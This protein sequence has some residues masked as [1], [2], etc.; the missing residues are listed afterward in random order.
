MTR[1]SFRCFVPAILATLFFVVGTVNPMSAQRRS[2]LGGQQSAPAAPAAIPTAQPPKPTAEPARPAEPPQTPQ[3]PS[4]DIEELKSNLEAANTA[5]AEAVAE[6]EQADQ[7]LA[8]VNTARNEAIG[9]LNELAKQK[10]ADDAQYNRVFSSRRL[11]FRLFLFA[12]LAAIGL[13]LH[14]AGRIPRKWRNLVAT[15]VA[16]AVLWLL[17]APQHAGAATIP[18]VT[19]CSTP[20]P[21]PSTAMLPAFFVNDGSTSKVAC[22]VSGLT[23]AT[24]VT[25]SDANLTTTNVSLTGNK[26]LFDLTVA[27]GATVPSEPD[28]LVDGKVV[29]HPIAV[30]GQADFDKMDLMLS[31]L[32]GPSAVSAAPT[33]D[34]VAREFIRGLVDAA[35]EG[36]S[37]CNRD[38]VLKAVFGPKKGS[39]R[40]A[41]YIVGTATR[42]GAVDSVFTDARYTDAATAT[43][44]ALTALNTA[45]QTAGA[46]AKTALAKADVAENKAE[47]ANARVGGVERDLTEARDLAE[48]A[49]ATAETVGEFVIEVSGRKTGGVLGIGRSPLASKERRCAL[50]RAL[51]KTELVSKLGCPAEN[52]K[53]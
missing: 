28:M 45:V 1:N 23:A 49:M 52:E 53:Q 13:A 6:R 31:Y 16:L 40:Q 17:V 35:C 37:Q 38:E 50:A 3:V 30:L 15:I 44:T 43:A 21:S 47:S 7:R 19:G 26:L 5:K 48:D 24:A 14:I 32:R 33:G 36:G 11:F 29:G 12:L 22:N 8:A 4:A 25:F 10:K 42:K 46:E 18:T 20:A 34:H 41:G 2:R 27:A 51:G 39:S 9:K